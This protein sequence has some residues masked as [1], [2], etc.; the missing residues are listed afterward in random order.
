MPS[1]RLPDETDQAF[2]R[3]AE[4]AG[5]YAKL[6]VEAALANCCIREVIADP[7][8]PYSEADQR[9]NPTVRIEFE[10]AIAIAGVGE[11]LDA[12]RH[13]HWGDGPYIHP[14]RPDDPF[15]PY[16]VLYIYKEG[17]RYNRRFKQRQR[18][19]QLLGRR[20]RPLVEKAK[21]QLHTQAIFLEYLT[22]EE[23]R[24]IWRILKIT[25]KTFWRAC[26]GKVWLNL[27]TRQQQTFF[28]FMAEVPMDPTVCYREMY[29]AM[30]D[31]DLQTARQRALDLKAWLGGNG[32][33]PQHHTK[34]EVDAYLANVLRRTA[35]V[36]LDE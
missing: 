17:S 24:A 14:L 31:G 34:T 33:Y 11:G 3:R 19:K 18:L 15:D 10:E 8:F 25:P 13:K 29:E 22:A 36:N 1:L 30:R 26:R 4:Q 16:F 35:G 6:L 21:R 28:D 23:E 5:R 2:R 12:T 27:P 20:F 32:F 9:T 7:T